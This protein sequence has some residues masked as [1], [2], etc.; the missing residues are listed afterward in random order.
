[1]AANPT[2]FDR[3]LLRARRQRASALGAETFLLDHVAAD[4]MERMASVLRQFDRA[5]DLGTPADTVRRALVTSG[6]VGLMVDAV[7]DTPGLDT[8]CPRVAADEEALPFADDSLELV[9]S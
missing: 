3:K 1:M 9:V 2:I 5:V 8:S 6:R 4:L 7:P